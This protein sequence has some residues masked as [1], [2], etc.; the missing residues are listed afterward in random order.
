MIFFRKHLKR[1]DEFFNILFQKMF[2]ELEKYEYETYQ[3]TNPPQTIYINKKNG[4]TLLKTSILNL[5]VEYE[6]PVFD[7]AWESLPGE[8]RE[9]INLI[10][11]RR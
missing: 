9:E 8:I 1:Y 7:A 6:G 5:H 4:E 2:E 3:T 11:K 10:Q